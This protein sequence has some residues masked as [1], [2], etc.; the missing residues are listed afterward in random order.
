MEVIISE[1]LEA[2]TYAVSSSFNVVCHPPLPTL[3]I[4]HSNLLVPRL[5]SSHLIIKPIC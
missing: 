2:H 1:V 3:I 5:L 4:S